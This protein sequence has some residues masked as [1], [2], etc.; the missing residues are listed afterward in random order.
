MHQ[1]MVQNNY[2]TV[3]HAAIVPLN[4]SIFPFSSSAWTILVHL[5]HLFAK[6]LGVSNV[7]LHLSQMIYETATHEQLSKSL[8]NM[9]DGRLFPFMMG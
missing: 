1:R 8:V 4:T 9:L 5:L 2:F 3:R 7:K 6:D